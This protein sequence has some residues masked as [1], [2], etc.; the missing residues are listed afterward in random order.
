VRAQIFNASGSKFGGEI[1]VNTST[2]G[3]Q[4]DP[5]VAGLSDGSFVVTWQDEPAGVDTDG[6]IRA[7]IFD[8]NGGTSGG[9]ILVNTTTAGEQ[10]DPTATMLSDG[11]FVVTWTDSSGSG[12]DTSGDALRGQ[13]FNAN[14]T[15]S[16]VEFLINT[17]TAG[18]QQGQAIAP[19]GDGRFVVAWADFSKT[20][21]DKDK[22]AIRAQVFNPDGSKSGKEFLVNTT[23]KDTQ[24]SPTITTLLDGRFVVAWSDFSHNGRD[25]SEAAVRAQIFDPRDGPVN[26]TGTA[27]GDDLVG[28]RFKD[29]FNGGAGDDRLDGGRGADTL[30][31]G[32]GADGFAFSDAIN[33]KTKADSIIDFSV[34][35]DSILLD[36]SVFAGIGKNG[37]L[38]GK[39]FHEGKKAHDGNDRIVYNDDTGKLTHDRNGDTKGGTVTFA[40][41]APGLDLSASDILVI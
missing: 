9:E 2:S 10:Y 38:K 35:E 16:G 34:P 13:V 25:K 30:T 32:L 29:V 18:N 33:R 37:A 24:T 21:G 26:V 4:L 6:D 22:G 12:G 14:G 1:L 19:L 39:F 17:T 20:G 11:R 40:K 5:W 8:A 15:K 3:A 7:Q 36:N 27:I 41:L 31:G 28:T 23:T